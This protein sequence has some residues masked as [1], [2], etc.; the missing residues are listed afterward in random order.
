MFWVLD[1]HLT[2][3]H[4]WPCLRCRT[5]KTLPRLSQ[6]VIRAPHPIGLSVAVEPAISWLSFSY[7]L[8]EFHCPFRQ[9]STSDTPAIQIPT[10]VFRG[11]GHSLILLSLCCFTFVTV[12]ASCCSLEPSCP[13]FSPSPYSPH[14]YY[15]PMLASPFKND[16]TNFAFLIIL[17]FQKIWKFKKISK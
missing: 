17:L 4:G 2:H 1:T 9:I 5:G 16:K 7:E 6:P 11:E 3:K 12:F 15:I 13:F 10:K 14:L 8:T